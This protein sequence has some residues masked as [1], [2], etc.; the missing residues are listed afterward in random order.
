[1]TQKEGVEN[2]TKEKTS[3]KKQDEVDT[4]EIQK[5]YYRYDFDRVKKFNKLAKSSVVDMSSGSGSGIL[6]RTFPKER[7][8]NALQN[9]KTNIDQLRNISNFLY[10]ISPQYRRLT[11]YYAEML[12]LDW[13]ISPYRLDLSEDINIDDF[14]KVYYETL[15][16]LDN[17]N[18][19]HEMLKALQILYREGIFYGYEHK[20]DES[21]FI[22]KL[23]PDFCQISSVEDGVFNFSFNFQ[24]FEG[25]EDELENFPKEFET[26]FNQYR[27]R[28][29]GSGSDQEDLQWQELDSENTIC[30]KTDES[31]TYP[32]PPFVGVFPEIYELQD[33]KALKKA[34]TEMEN[35]ALL[36]GKIPMN[37][38]SGIANDFSLTLDT[39]LQFGRRMNNELPDQMG[40]I[41]SVFDELEMFKLNDDKVG[42]NKVEEA[43]HSFWD[44]AGVTSNLFTE[45][46]STDAAVKAALTTDEQS[47]FAILR[48]IERW[49]NRK[50]KLRKGSYQFQIHMLNTTWQNRKERASEEIKAAQFSVPN[51]IKLAAT[52]GIGQS[53]VSSMAFLEN[54]VLGLADSW[55]PLSSSHTGGKDNSPTEGDAGRPSEE[56]ETVRTDNKTEKGD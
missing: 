55:Q 36:S 13:Y 1:M 43:V 40:F 48:Q 12:T 4:L 23:H 15:F 49:V 56:E 46:G 11:N 32:L 45:G 26:K 5:K 16:E 51:K 39:A 35:I 18:I 20:N 3:E 21:Y 10:T 14:Q 8:V 37:K 41:L 31:V 19:K 44:S 52:L 22:K 53:E 7:V 2:L 50:L 42:T 27:N 33:Y 47:V 34:N 30:L 28:S 38:N 29:G 9:P 17:M 24:Y 54:E 25:N 6:F